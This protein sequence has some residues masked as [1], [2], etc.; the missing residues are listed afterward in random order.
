MDEADR[1]ILELTRHGIPV[2]ESPYSA[3]AEKVGIGTQEVLDRLSRMK[4]DGTIRRFSASIDQH[5]LGIHANAVVA[6]KVPSDRVEEVAKMMSSS[7]IFTHC[8]E[9]AKVPGM[10]E[11]DLYTVIHGM[12]R[13]SVKEQVDAFSRT[14]NVLDYDIF[15]SIRDLRSSEYSMEGQQ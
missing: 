12:D 2:V 3:I 9:R 8:Y 13:D 1:K 6:W 7:E 14:V 4:D 11:Y 5:S 15:F 10:W